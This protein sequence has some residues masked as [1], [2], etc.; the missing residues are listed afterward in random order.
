MT[1]LNKNYWFTNSVR[2]NVKIKHKLLAK[3]LSNKVF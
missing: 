3:R 1:R 2:I